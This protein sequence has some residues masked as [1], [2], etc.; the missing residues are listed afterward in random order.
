[1]SLSLF[2]PLTSLQNMKLAELGLWYGCSRTKQISS[3]LLVQHF[4]DDSILD[5]LNSPTVR[6]VPDVSTT[7][8]DVPARKETGP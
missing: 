8:V 3:R 6:A 2:L 1:M 5:R 7:V 4:M